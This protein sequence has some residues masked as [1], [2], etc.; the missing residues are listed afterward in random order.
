MIL[1]DFLLSDNSVIKIA[2]IFFRWKYYEVCLLT[3]GYVQPQII[4]R[5]EENT[6]V[7]KHIVEIMELGRTSEG[8][9]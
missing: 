5:I 7:L 6:A 3:L 4:E 9:L 1:I 2:F 8:T